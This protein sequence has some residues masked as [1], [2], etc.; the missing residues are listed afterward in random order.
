MK[1]IAHVLFTFIYSWSQVLDCIYAALK[2]LFSNFFIIWKISPIMI[3]FC[4]IL[5]K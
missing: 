3:F 2:K 1:Y 4:R 5:L